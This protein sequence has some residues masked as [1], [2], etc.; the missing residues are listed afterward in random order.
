MRNKKTKVYHSSQAENGTTDYFPNQGTFCDGT[1]FEDVDVVGNMY[2]IDWL[3]L[4]H[5]VL[6]SSCGYFG[7]SFNTGRLWQMF[8]FDAYEK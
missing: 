6:H 7:S 8:F 1:L 3:Y 4:M 5:N 2:I